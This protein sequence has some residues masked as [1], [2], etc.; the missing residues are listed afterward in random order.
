MATFE[1]QEMNQDFY[2]E[3][4]FVEMFK[5]MGFEATRVELCFTNGASAYISVNTMVVNENKM[6]ADCFVYEGMC[7]LTVRVSDHSSNLEKICGGVCKNKLS[8]QAFKKIVENGTIV[9]A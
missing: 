8:L 2:T 7:S 3:Q 5:E 1:K 6:Y 4:Y 9:N